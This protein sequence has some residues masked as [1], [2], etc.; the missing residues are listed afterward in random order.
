MHR[1]DVEIV[2]RIERSFIENGYIPLTGSY[3]NKHTPMHCG[4]GAIGCLDGMR[5]DQAGRLVGRSVLWVK[6]FTSGFDMSESNT[7]FPWFERCDDEWRRGYRAGWICG[8][9]IFSK[10]PAEVVPVA[11]PVHV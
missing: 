1:G 11:E 7:L 9:R 8:K 6:G 10:A 5:E 4:L 3:G 2:E